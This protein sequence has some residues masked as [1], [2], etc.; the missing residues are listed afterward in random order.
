[1]IDSY[2]KNSS[3]GNDMVETSVFLDLPITRNQLQATPPAVRTT[4]RFQPTRRIDTACP[5]RPWPARSQGQRQ[6]GA[7]LARHV[8][9]RLRPLPDIRPECSHTQ[10][11]HCTHLPSTRPHLRQPADTRSCS[12]CSTSSPS[13]CCRRLWPCSNSCISSTLQC[14]RPAPTRPSPGCRQLEYDSRL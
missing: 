8:Y 10:L 4:R 11:A 7:N 2:C 9:R 13:C 3:D 1:M 5:N 14:S 6:S 12:S